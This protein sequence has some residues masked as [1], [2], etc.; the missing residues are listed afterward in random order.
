M[1]P[2]YRSIYYLYWL[3]IDIPIQKTAYYSMTIRYMKRK[4]SKEI[5]WKK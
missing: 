2:T 5:A 1:P 4:K 3:D